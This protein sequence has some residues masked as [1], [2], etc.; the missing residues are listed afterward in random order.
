[1]THIA[2]ELNVVT[3]SASAHA[4]QVSSSLFRKHQTSVAEAIPQ[5]VAHQEE[6]HPQ[7]PLQLSYKKRLC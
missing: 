3:L 5:T 2:I 4:G 1:V 6:A 7:V